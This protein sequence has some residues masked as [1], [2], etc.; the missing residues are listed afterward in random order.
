MIKYPIPK[1]IKSGGCIVGDGF[2]NPT[3]GMIVFMTIVTFWTK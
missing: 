3:L 2:Q 1:P